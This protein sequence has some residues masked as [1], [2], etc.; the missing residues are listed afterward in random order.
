VRDDFSVPRFVG[1][2]IALMRDY[3]QQTGKD[4][5]SH[6]FRKAAFPTGGKRARP[7]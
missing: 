5:S 3:Q 2:V 7:L 4:L 1:W 6:D